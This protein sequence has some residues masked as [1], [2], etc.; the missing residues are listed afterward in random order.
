MITKFNKYKLITEDPDSFYDG[1][2]YIQ[3]GDQDARPFF[4][5][6]DQNHTQVEKI[7]VGDYCST[8]GSIS[9]LGKNKAY[10]GRLWDDSKIISFWVY[11][12]IN[13]FKQIINALEDKLELKIFNNDW[14]VEVIKTDEGDIKVKEFRE[15]GDYYDEYFFRGNEDEENFSGDSEIIPVEEY[16]GSENVPEEKQ[17]QHLM[18]WKEKELARKLGKIHFGNFGSKL[19]SWDQPHNIKWRQAMYQ[20]NKKNYDNR[21]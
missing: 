8:H 4:V 15:R 3:Y 16:A 20:E 17:I 9:Y 18:N 2:S 10:A 1:D 12:S 6:V 7:Y 11:P 14:R 21:I 19:T 5:D 13:L